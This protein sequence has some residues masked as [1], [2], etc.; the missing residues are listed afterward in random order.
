[1]RRGDGV[2]VSFFWGVLKGQGGIIFPSGAE[3]GYAPEG[4]I[5]PP[6]PIY[7]LALEMKAGPANS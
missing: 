4:K 2:I 3:R 6:C 1:M 7:V 5:M